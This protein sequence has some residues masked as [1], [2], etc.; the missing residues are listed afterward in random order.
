MAHL[1]YSRDL[2]EAAT[3]SA[4]LGTYQ[5]L[6]EGIVAHPEH[7]MAQLPLLTEQERQQQLSQWNATQVSYPQRCIHQLF[8]EQV[9]ATPGAIA[10]IFAER[11]MT[12]EQL[13]QRA[14]QLAHHLHH[15]GV[16]PEVLVGVCMDRS[17]EMV[18]SLLAILKR[19]ACVPLDPTY[20][21]SDWPQ[22]CQLCQVP[23]CLRKST[24]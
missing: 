18:V 22:L 3:I 7:P 4:S 8:E 16:G 14:N 20:P 17:L 5:I 2:F 11:Q 13:N 6:L 19:V 9:R 1:E 15:L 21:K 10:L 12:Y 24:C 23:A